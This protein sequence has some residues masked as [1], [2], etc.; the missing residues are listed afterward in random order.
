MSR[1]VTTPTP[2]M[3][4]AVSQAV[5]DAA[6]QGQVY[7]HFAFFSR[8]TSRWVGEVAGYVPYPDLPRRGPQREIA[9]ARWQTAAIRGMGTQTEIVDQ[10]WDHGRIQSEQTVGLDVTRF[11]WPVGDHIWHRWIDLEQMLDWP[12]SSGHRFI[13]VDGSTLQIRAQQHS[14]RPVRSAVPGQYVLDITGTALEPYWGWLWG[15]FV[16]RPDG[17][18]FEPSVTH[19]RGQIDDLVTAPPVVRR[20]LTEAPVDWVRAAIMRAAIPVGG[21]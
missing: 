15:R 10:V 6:P 12:E 14:H 18:G 1:L 20:Q 17:I 3:E 7:R 5:I 4:Y 16:L 11:A 2:H 9:L 21:R 8:P 13:E 19:R